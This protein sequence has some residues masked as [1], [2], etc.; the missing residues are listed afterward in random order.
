MQD[1][2][3]NFPDGIHPNEKAEDIKKLLTGTI[4]TIT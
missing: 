4:Y 1:Q 2:D 3:T